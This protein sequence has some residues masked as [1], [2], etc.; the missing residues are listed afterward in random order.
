MKLANTQYDSLAFIHSAAVQK[1]LHDPCHS[2]MSAPTYCMEKA[3]DGALTAT[4]SGG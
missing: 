2:L 4:S 1:C 3:I